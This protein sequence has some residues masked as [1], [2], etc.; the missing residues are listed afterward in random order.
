[1]TLTIKTKHAIAATLYGCV[2][3]AF[4]IALHVSSG[5]E[6]IITHTF[7]CKS[8]GD[9]EFDHLKERVESELAEIEPLVE[10]VKIETQTLH[11]VVF[12]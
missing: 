8:K 12:N 10:S 2:N 5:D 11:D 3:E 4:K 7:I 1:M 6:E 9:K